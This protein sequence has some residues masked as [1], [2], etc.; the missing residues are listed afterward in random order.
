VPFPVRR[1]GTGCLE[2]GLGF[3][4]RTELLS[5]K[6][7]SQFVHILKEEQRLSAKNVKRVC[8]LCKKGDAKLLG[9]NPWGSGLLFLRKQ[10]E[11]GREGQEKERCFF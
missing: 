1:D 11:K 8:T 3:R 4:E 7:R 6:N 10:K 5:R 9:D 2:A